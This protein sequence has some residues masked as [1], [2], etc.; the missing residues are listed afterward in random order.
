MKLELAVRGVVGDV[1]FPGRNAGALLKLERGLAQL[2]LFGLFP[3]RNVGASLKQRD[4]FLEVDDVFDIF[5]GRA[6][7]ASLKQVG[8]TKA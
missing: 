8:F 1:L 7:R 6:D 3:G 4:V 5:P 2:Q